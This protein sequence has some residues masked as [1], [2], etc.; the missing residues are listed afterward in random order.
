ME[1]SGFS[2]NDAQRL[3]V[4]LLK[5]LRLKAKKSKDRSDTKHTDTAQTETA[6]LLFFGRSQLDAIAEEA[7]AKVAADI[8]TLDDAEL[9]EKLVDIKA[10]DALMVGHPLEVALFGRM[11]AD[12]ADLNVDAAVQVAH[13]LSTHPVEFEYDYF[14]AIDDEKDRSSG[15]DLG[16]VMLGTVEFNSATMYRYATIATHQLLENLG[17]DRNH[18]VEGVRRFIEGFVRSIPSGHQNT[19]AHRTLPD[20]VV[21]V[22]RTDQPVNL[23]SAFERPVKQKGGYK[24]ESVVALAEEYQRI[25][26]QWGGNPKLVASLYPR[27]ITEK[28]SATFGPGVSFEEMIAATVS[29]V[30]GH[31]G[32]TE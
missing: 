2:E 13:A 4:A 10:K 12:L 8:T 31:M 30:S 14:T 27:E 19:F 23:V 32:L 22:A 1:K 6:Y 20:A 7:I 18:T 9:E 28:V 17:D 5:P 25:D 21:V 11:V 24:E 29:V 16:A 15:D 26:E 3:A